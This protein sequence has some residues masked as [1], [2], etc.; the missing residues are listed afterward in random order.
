[1]LQGKDVNPQCR[2]AKVEAFPSWVINGT[3]YEGKLTFTQLKQHLAG[4]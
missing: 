2:D 1:M 4:Q 3:K